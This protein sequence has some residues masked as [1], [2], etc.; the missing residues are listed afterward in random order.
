MNRKIGKLYE[1]MA[2]NFRPKKVRKLL[3]AECPPVNGKYFYL[4]KANV[5]DAS[6]AG[7]IFLH[8]FRRNPRDV[9][10]YYRFLRRL[11]KKGVFLID[12]LNYPLKVRSNKRNRSLI[13]KEIPR[14]KTNIKARGIRIKEDKIT[15]LLPRVSYKKI[16]VQHFPR[17]EVKRW[18]EFREKD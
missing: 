3:I 18:K 1:N 6:L 10:E 5:K 8:H 9:D 13:K 16:I 4:P 14:L 7:T 15:F 17:A 11:Q 2:N 12:I